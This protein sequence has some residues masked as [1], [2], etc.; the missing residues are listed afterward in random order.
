VYKRQA[1]DRSRSYL[2]N[3]AITNYIELH[4][5]QAVS[6]THLDVYKRQEYGRSIFGQTIGIKP[7]ISLEQSDQ[8]KTYEVFSTSF[9]PV[10]LT[11]LGIEIDI[12]KGIVYR[13]SLIHI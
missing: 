10:A 3:E 11:G 8:G 7:F 4:A 2:I 5:Y 6:Y 12:G 9:G 13:L 1:Q